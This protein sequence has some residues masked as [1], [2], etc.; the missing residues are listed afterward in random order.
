MST[1]AISLIESRRL[2]E[3]EE[4]IERG[5]STFIQVGEALAEIRD[6]YRHHFKSLGYSNF[7]DYCIKKWKF[8]RYTAYNLMNAAEVVTNV[9]HAQHLTGANKPASIRQALSLRKLSGTEQPKAWS[10]AVSAANGSQPTAK[11]VAAAVEE[12]QAETE[13]ET[14]TE[15]A[16][17]TGRLPGPS[18]GMKYAWQAIESL[19]MIQPNDT[20]RDKA[21]MAV[22]RFLTQN[23]QQK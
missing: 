7:E 3:L 11:Q 10:A 12:V 4:V 17:R 13:T 21:F 19:K 2:V 9:E 6:K 15:T 23:Y 16:P 22:Q 18:N 14:E 20:E 5:L 8:S 1:E